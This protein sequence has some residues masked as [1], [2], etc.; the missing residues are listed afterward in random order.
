MVV[1]A[2]LKSSKLASSRPRKKFK[3]ASTTVL[4]IGELADRA[5]LRTSALRY[6]EAEGLLAPAERISG[7]RRYDESAVE[8]LAVIGFCQA[9]GFTLAEI[10]LLM[11]EPRGA[12]QKVH[13]RHLVDAKLSE[14]DQAAARVRSMKKILKASR[15]CDCLDVQECARVCHPRMLAR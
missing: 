7:H 8:R 11:S 6:Y 10:K 5:N 14:L 12:R 13:W 15:D 2:D 4:T 9:L 3:Y 1:K